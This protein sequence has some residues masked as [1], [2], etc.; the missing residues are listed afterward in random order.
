MTM[1]RHDVH[2]VCLTGVARKRDR[3]CELPKGQKIFVSSSC[4]LVC[5]LNWLEWTG[6]YELRDGTMEACA[7]RE[8]REETGLSMASCADVLIGPR[9]AVNAYDYTK[10]STKKR[11]NR[12]PHHAADYA[13]A[14]PTTI[15]PSRAAA[16]AVAVAAPS[17]K[18][19]KGGRSRPGPGPGAGA[20]AGASSSSSGGGS[21]SASS[22]SESSALASSG[23]SERIK[24]SVHYFLATQRPGAPP[25][26]FSAAEAHADGTQVLL[27]FFLL[28][29]FFSIPLPPSL[30]PSPSLPPSVLPLSLPVLFG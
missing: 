21:G 8:L 12:Q 20:G 11:S 2:V 29:S 5:A 15:I 25:P 3:E 23:G 4:I 9:I 1:R 10:Q 14:T 26:V 18:G 27:S 6:R 24:K 30:L 13:P 17:G 22:S 16:V 19:K 7:M 28:L